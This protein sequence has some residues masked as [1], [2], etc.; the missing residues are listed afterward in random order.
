MKC[1]GWNCRGL[2]NSRTVRCLRDL[3]KTRNPDFVFLSETLVKTEKIG[4]L[5]KSFGFENNFTVSCVGHGGGLAVMWK[6][7]VT[8]TILSSSRNHI[9]VEIWDHNAPSWRITGFYG[10]PERQRR[11]DSWEFLKSLAAVSQIPWCVFGDFNDLRYESDKMGSI[12]HPQSLMDGFSETI[13]SCQLT[14]IDLEGG[15]FTWEKSR[16]KPN[17]VRERLDRAFASSSWL[18]KF[19]LCTL[20]VIHTTASDHDP[21]MLE[22]CN[23]TVSRKKFR[24]RFENVWLKE[25]SFH[26][27]VL[28]CWKQLP[29][30]HLL[31]KLVAISEFMAQWGHRFFH[32][33]RDKVRSQKKII[34]ELVDRTDSDGVNFFN[35]GC[36]Q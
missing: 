18:H 35:R 24:F 11:K 19:P 26:D 4:E 31:P 28:G 10:F 15:Q 32:K 2:G 12:A 16:G 17:W 30:S 36:D 5:S 6:R 21:I 27:E 23:V 9:D 33:F 3:L 1:L 20:T 25:P 13:E 34:D 14:E 7:N 22:L 29:V 8:C